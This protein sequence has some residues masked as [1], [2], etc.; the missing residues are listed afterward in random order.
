MFGYVGGAA[1]AGTSASYAGHAAAG[2]ISAAAGGGNCGQGA[3]SAVFGKFTTNAIGGSSELSGPIAKGVASAVAGGVGSM[4]AGGKFENGA[5]TAAYGYLFNELQHYKGSTRNRLQLGGYAFVA[6]EGIGSVTWKSN[7]PNTIPVDGIT[8]E[9]LQCTARC[10]GQDIQATGGQE[11]WLNGKDGS[12][13]LH[14]PN[15]AHYSNEAVDFRALTVTNSK[16]LSCSA[17][18]GFGAGW[19]EGGKQPHWHFQQTPGNGVP[20]IK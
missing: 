4:I 2:C 15:S 1:T 5:V 14:S 12:K 3:V 7:Y 13:L 9:A 18:C 8:G 20:P 16:V 19:W 17:N 6:D 11:K 10:T